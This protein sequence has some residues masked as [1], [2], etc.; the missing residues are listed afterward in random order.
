ML[1]EF[2]ED[3]MESL[4]PSLIIAFLRGK[5]LLSR[6][7]SQIINKKKFNEEMILEIIDIMA[8]KDGWW[9]AL[10]EFLKNQTNYV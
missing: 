1:D 10:M 9:E 8:D 5:R 6:A 4:N 3:L 2:T 7:E